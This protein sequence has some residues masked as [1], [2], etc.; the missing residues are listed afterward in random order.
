MEVKTM[1]KRL[2]NVSV[3]RIATNNGEYIVQLERLKNTYAGNP[4][5]KATIT[6][7]N[8]FTDGFNYSPV[9]TF[10]GHYCGDVK[11]AEWVVN[12]HENTK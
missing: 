6:N 4:R 9:Y 8:T 11:E 7:L 5:F 2:N 1:T 12:Y 3:Y 10:T